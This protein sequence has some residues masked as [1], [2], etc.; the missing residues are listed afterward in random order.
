MTAPL[1]K[2][3]DAFSETAIDDE[4]VVMSLSSGDFFSLTDT[5]RAIW[6]LVDGQRD[7]AAVIAALQAEYGSVDPAEVAAFLA[8]LCDAGFVS[9]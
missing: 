4:I 2:L 3:S 1:H 7:E 6:L 8:D 5:A 9:A